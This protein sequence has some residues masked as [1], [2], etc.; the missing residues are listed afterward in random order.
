MFQHDLK[1]STNSFGIMCRSF[2]APLQTCAA[3][4]Q[5]LCHDPFRRFPCGIQRRSAELYNFD[6]VESM[7]ILALATLISH[8]AGMQWVQGL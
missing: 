2:L 5:A 4:I 6:S 8:I 1:V 7:N 3:D